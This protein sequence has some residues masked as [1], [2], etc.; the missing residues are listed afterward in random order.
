MSWRCAVNTYQ[1]Q[2]QNPWDSDSCPVTWAGNKE[3]FLSSIPRCW[4]PTP[5]P[6]SM[7]C[8][9]LV[10][11]TSVFGCSGHRSLAQLPERYWK[12]QTKIYTCNF[13]FPDLWQLRQTFKK[14][15][16]PIFSPFLSL[17]IIPDWWVQSLM[18][19][20]WIILPTW[21]HQQIW[22]EV[23]IMNGLCKLDLRDGAW[24]INC[25]LSSFLRK[26]SDDLSWWVI[27][28]FFSATCKFRS[29]E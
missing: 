10:P 25:V 29:F 22:G 2:A 28:P 14:S 6:T 17:R 12:N 7:E 20:A 5:F 18:L 24:K 21:Q 4:S 11:T 19:S 23:G 26:Q 27:C 1:K 13:V 16:T 3:L 8:S 9:W 15:L